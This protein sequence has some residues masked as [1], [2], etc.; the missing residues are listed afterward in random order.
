MNTLVRTAA[1]NAWAVT[2]GDGVEPPHAT[3]SVVLYDDN[4]QLLRRYGHA[5]GGDGEPVL[6]VPPL[7]APAT[8]FDLRAGQSLAEFL[9]YSGRTPYLVDYG[10]IGF[11][12]RAMGM[13]N[14]IDEIIPNAVRRAS[15]DSGGRTVDIVTWSRGGS[16]SLLTAAAH[17]ELLVAGTNDV[18]CNV[19]A[20]RAATEVLTGSPFVRFETAP[21]SH[22]GVLTG[23]TA[24]TSTWAYLDE[25]LREQASLPFVD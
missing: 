11:A 7:A 20:A 19:P 3:S 18:I 15:R 21:G 6:L 12:D 5:G 1:R 23:T 9:L 24:R 22:L 4:H 2:L 17:P 14:W 10:T 16:L 13:E 8:C 25:F